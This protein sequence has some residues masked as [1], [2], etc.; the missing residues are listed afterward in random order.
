M[1]KHV[2]FDFDGTIADSLNQSLKI[3]NQLAAKYG[4][5]EITEGEVKELK[6]LPIEE[7]LKR[8]NIKLYFLPKLLIEFLKI[9]RNHVGSI[10]LIY[11]VDCL[12]EDLKSSGFKLGIISSNNLDNI[13]KFLSDKQLH[14]FDFVYSSKGLFGKHG[15]I[16]SCLRKFGIN[17]DEV[18][19][20]GDELRDIHACKKSGIRIISVTW[21]F[22]PP[23]LL[24]KGNPDFIANTPF[25]VLNH[26]KS[27]N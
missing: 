10:D 15:T 13:N 1:L 26:I 25:E 18:I 6:Y 11:G 8:Y 22:D 16:N 24:T 20:I 23:D 4:F 17:K 19:Y 12:L 21:G 27:I 14:T 7:R 5:P 2:I 9:Y 3:G